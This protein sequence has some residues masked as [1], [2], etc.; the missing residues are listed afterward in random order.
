VSSR[1][2]VLHDGDGVK[3][4]VRSKLGLGGGERDIASTVPSAV[5]CGKRVSEV[6][7]GI[8]HQSCGEISVLVGEGCVA[9]P[10]S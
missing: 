1:L 6:L 8:K 3:G 5:S 2:E 7:I 10:C 9:G 4:G